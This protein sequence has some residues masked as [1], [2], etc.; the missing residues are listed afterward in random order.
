[1]SHSP[2]YKAIVVAAIT[3]L[4]KEG[5]HHFSLEK[6]AEIAR[7]DI[8]QIRD[9]FP[10]PNKLIQIALKQS[11]Y[12]GFVENLE[13]CVSNF[14][15]NKSFLI[16]LFDSILSGALHYPKITKSHFYTAF[17]LKKESVG[18]H[19]VNQFND[20]IWEILEPTIEPY[21][22][23]AVKRKLEQA[24]AS[25]LFVALF[26]LYS[27]KLKPHRWAEDLARSIIE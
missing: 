7:R 4:E 22:K 2:D 12:N 13:D 6:V 17:T 20:R 24:I 8:S 9:L 18:L 21:R 3:V 26:P 15:D 14:H 25:I 19:E 1:M 5:F 27:P 23:D 16:E 10:D 11:I